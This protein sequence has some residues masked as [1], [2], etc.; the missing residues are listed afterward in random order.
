MSDLDDIARLSL[1]QTSI[2]GQPS[3]ENIIQRPLKDT[4]QLEYKRELAKKRIAM[5]DTELQI[6]KKKLKSIEEALRTGRVKVEVVLQIFSGR[7]DP[8]WTLSEREIEELRKLLDLGLMK[9]LKGR[10]EPKMGLGYRGFLIL[11]EAGIRGIPE[12]MEVARH[13]VTIYGTGIEEAPEVDKKYATIS[14]VRAGKVDR[15]YYEDVNRIEIWLLEQAVKRGYSD[16]IEHFGG[17][18]MK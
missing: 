3:R 5:L 13:T 10:Q 7:P 16:E 6:A 1:N 2:Q 9:P 17:P 4:N 12:R 8:A 14:M 11:N 18:S 15:S